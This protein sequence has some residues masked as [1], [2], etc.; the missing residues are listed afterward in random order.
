[1]VAAPVVG[2][3]ARG[4][5]GAVALQPMID[6]GATGPKQASE[7]G[8]WLSP[9][10]LQTREGASEDAGLRRLSQL[11]FEPVSLRECVEQVVVRLQP[12]IAQKHAEVAID[13]AADFPKIEQGGSFPLSTLR[14]GPAFAHLVGELKGDAMR[15][16]F[17]QKFS[18]D[19]EHRPVTITAR[20]L[21]RAKD[22]RIHTDSRDKLLVYAKS[23]LLPPSSF[24]GLSLL[25]GPDKE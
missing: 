6:A 24:T 8:D 16:A 9:G 2:Q 10:G 3:G 13:I 11:L 17:A 14:Y 7:C 23:G 5:Q 12:R 25:P 19:L 21:T 22:G 20:G 18:V 1:M 15:R 4:G